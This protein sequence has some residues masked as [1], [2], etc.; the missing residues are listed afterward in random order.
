MGAPGAGFCS[1]CL[2]GDYPVPVRVEIPSARADRTEPGARIV[3]EVVPL[4]LLDAASGLM[5][6][7]EAA[8][9]RADAAQSALIDNAP[10]AV[11][12][13]ADPAAVNRTEGVVG[14]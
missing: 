13:D 7:D 12:D 11:T 6:A 10:P 9:Q 1:A 4:S 14:G 3:E 8:A 2:T 5:P